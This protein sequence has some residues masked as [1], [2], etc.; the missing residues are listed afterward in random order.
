MELQA[1]RNSPQSED[2]VQR[3][4]TSLTQAFPQ[5]T[6]FATESALSTTGVLKDRCD[7]CSQNLRACIVA[8]E[9]AVTNSSTLEKVKL[10]DLQTRLQVCY[11][12]ATRMFA[13]FA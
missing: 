9:H 12:V 6:D 1:R 3:S 10:R 5:I 11:S 4:T 7:V 13:L 2:K 8:I